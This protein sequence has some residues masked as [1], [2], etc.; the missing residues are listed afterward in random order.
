M[1]ATGQ[2]TLRRAANDKAVTLVF[3][4]KN[5]AVTVGAY[6][7]APNKNTHILTGAL[8]TQIE[9]AAS[10]CN[11][12]FYALLGVFTAQFLLGL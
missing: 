10:I 7:I 1:R 4:T 3:H 11:G 12:V 8:I 2:H 9:T 5:S 6:L